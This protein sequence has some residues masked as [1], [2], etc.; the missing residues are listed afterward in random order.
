[1]KCKDHGGPLTSV[2]ELKALV[3]KKSPD[4][5]SFLRQELQYQ[6]LTHQQDSTIH[7]DLYKINLVSEA[8]MIENLT[9]L[10]G[11]DYQVEEAVVFISEEEIVQLLRGEGNKDKETIEDEALFLP[12]QPLAV[13]WEEGGNK[14]CFIG[15][16]VD[17][18]E[19]ST[20]RVSHLDRVETAKDVWQRPSGAD[21]IQDVTQAQIVPQDVSG[22]WDFSNLRKPQFILS[23]AAEIEATFLSIQ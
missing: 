10:L 19:D 7:K 9:I 11:D 3:T 21:D 12:N 15:F 8:D 20:F 14:L 22:N 18:N 4:L 23:N 16:Y 2:T 6:R 5:K 13:I 17:D 1:M